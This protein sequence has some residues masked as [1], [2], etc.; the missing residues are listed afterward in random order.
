MPELIQHAATPEAI[1]EQIGQLLSDAEMRHGLEAR[2]A[3]MH[4]TL[5]RNASERAAQAITALVAGE[6]LE[7]KPD[8]G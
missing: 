4:A 7:A 6:L 3:A 5:Q 2:F 8:G 1:A